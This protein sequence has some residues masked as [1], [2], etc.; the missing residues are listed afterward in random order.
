MPFFA[1]KKAHVYRCALIMVKI[2]CL[3]ECKYRNLCAMCLLETKLAVSRP[4][5]PGESRQQNLLKYLGESCGNCNWPV[6]VDICWIF[7][8]AFEYW[9]D[10]YVHK[11]IRYLTSKI[12]QE[13]NI[14]IIDS[15]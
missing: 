3:P 12:Q 14:D 5:V 15:S 4:Q 8:F 7:L 1:I 13:R 11:G 10:R 6:I 2:H 9:Y